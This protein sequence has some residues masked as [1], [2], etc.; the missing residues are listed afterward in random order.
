MK[1]ILLKDVKKQGKKSDQVIRIWTGCGYPDCVH[2][3]STGGKDVWR[4]SE[5]RGRTS[6]NGEWS[7]FYR[8][9][10]WIW[11]GRV[12]WTFERSEEDGIWRWS[13]DEAGGETVSAF[14][15][16]GEK[17]IIRSRM[18]SSRSGCSLLVFW[19]KFKCV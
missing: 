8:K 15:S 5:R 16:G 3:A 12:F 18:G 6:E 9:T 13:T 10:D 4:V 7:D 2:R 11:Q 14:V 19:K 1:V 17:Q